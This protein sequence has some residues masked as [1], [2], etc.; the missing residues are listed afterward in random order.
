MRY[1]FLPVRLC[2]LRRLHTSPTQRLDSASKVRASC[3]CTGMFNPGRALY[4]LLVQGLHQRVSRLRVGLTAQQH[5]FSNLGRTSRSCTAVLMRCILLQP[6]NLNSDP[7]PFLGNPGGINDIQTLENRTCAATLSTLTPR[8]PQQ[9]LLTACNRQRV[10]LDLNVPR[11]FGS[12]KSRLEA[13]RTPLLR[14][15]VTCC[16]DLL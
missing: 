6:L 16:F 10:C 11:R 2:S 4:S 13:C 9:A 14:K 15:N 12:D 5:L 1:F 7:G 3:E 8:Q